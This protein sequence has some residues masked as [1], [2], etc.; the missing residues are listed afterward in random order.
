MN[1]GDLIWTA[2]L[3]QLDHGAGPKEAYIARAL[4]ESVEVGWSVPPEALLYIADFLDKPRPR[5]R[6]KKPPKRPFDEVTDALKAAKF[7]LDVER[8]KEELRASDKPST[9]D[10]QLA[11]YRTQHRK[12]A[13]VTVARDYR[14]AR[15]IIRPYQDQ[16]AAAGRD[17]SCVH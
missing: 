4:R 12:A 5:G 16:L 15:Q 10:A 14:R 13:K 8:I 6:P 9:R 3:E 11:E 7:V 1:V 2:L 17:R